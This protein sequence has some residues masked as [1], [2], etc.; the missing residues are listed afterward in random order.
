MYSEHIPKYKIRGIDLWGFRSM[1]QLVL[2]RLPLFYN[3]DNVTQKT[4][5]ATL[6]SFFA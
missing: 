3:M 5:I 1:G 4:V 2:V 6:Q